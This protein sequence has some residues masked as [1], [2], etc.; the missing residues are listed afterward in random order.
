MSARRP[1][2]LLATS[3]ALLVPAALA[4]SAASAKSHTRLCDRSVEFAGTTTRLAVRSGAQ[5][6]TAR[7]VVRRFDRGAGG[8]GGKR[9][10][11][12]LAHAPFDEKFGR[13]VG[14]TCRYRKTR[15]TKIYGLL[16]CGTADRAHAPVRPE[17]VR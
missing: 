17:D 8:S 7:A 9:Y 16:P 5:C 6:D 1:L 12:Y 10:G 4:P 14:F 11:C 13:Q 3:A 2:T 15:H